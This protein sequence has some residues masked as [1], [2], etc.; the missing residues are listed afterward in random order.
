[1][2]ESPDQKKK[3][4]ICRPALV[5][6]CRMEKHDCHPDAECHDVPVGY[7]CQCRSQFFDSSPNKATHPGRVCTP[8]PTPSPEE[9]R[10]DV[11]SSCKVEL[12]EVCRIINGVPKCSCPINYNRDPIKK[13]CT[14]I[15]ECQ[16]PQLNDCHPNAECQ[17]TQE[18]YTCKCLPNFKD[19]SSDERPGRNCQPL[20]NECQF[21]HLNDC[22][23]KAQCI[24]LPE[25]YDC[26]CLNGF[27]DISS[28]RPGRICQQLIN[29]CARPNS[30]SCHKDALCTDLENGYK[31]ACKN[32]FLDVSPS[33]TLPGRACRPSNL[34]LLING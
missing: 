23:Q 25:G 24:D 1:M 16:F 5:D 34:F 2:D 22:H 29:E 17:D 26:K 14:L 32:N 20:V 13:A 33:P 4:R 10:L 9:C 6:E 7:T 19:V 15:N 12:N 18:L 31:C 28:E 27:K 8:R 30:N 11:S 21:A 3:G